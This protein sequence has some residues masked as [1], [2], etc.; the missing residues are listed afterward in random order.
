M[1]DI[2][3]NK[4]TINLKKSTFRFKTVIVNGDTFTAENLNVEHFRNGDE[5]FE[6][7]TNME[8]IYCA[9]NEI[10]AWCYLDNDRTNGSTLGKLYNAYCII[11]KREIAPKGWEILSDI[12]IYDYYC[13][14]I[15]NIPRSGARSANGDFRLRNCSFW[16]FKFTNRDFDY[17]RDCVKNDYVENRGYRNN[18]WNVTS[19][20]GRY[21]TMNYEIDVRYLT[22]II[23]GGINLSYIEPGY[24]G[25]V[26]LGDGYSIRLKKIIAK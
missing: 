7:K 16:T 22:G 20:N 10:P 9:E 2:N 25:I 17:I 18:Q 4:N 11:D 3:L 14:I 6:A 12:N 26:K 19:N 1:N 24:A 15:N 13:A 23:K 21:N 8:W 5:I